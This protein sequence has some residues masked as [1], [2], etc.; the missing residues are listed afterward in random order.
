M[1]LFDEFP[2]ITTKEWMEKIEADL[3]GADFEKKLIYR[4]PEGIA[5]KPFYREE[6]L[7]GLDH[8]QDLA[9]LKPGVGTGNHWSICQD[10]FPG[11]N[12]TGASAERIKAALKGGAQAIRIL[13]ADVGRVDEDLILDLLQDVDPVE[14]PVIFQGYLGADA[15]LGHLRTLAERKGLRL[16]DVKAC[17]GADPLCKM[18]TTGIHVASFT[19]LGQLV[20]ECTGEAPG[21]RVIDVNGARY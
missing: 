4:S 21:I 3:R 13:L 12:G 2:S 19:T 7:Q 15:L 17:L 16:Q 20:K 1:Q 8:Q 6:D 5:V 10:I 14:T 9:S 18:I 11:L